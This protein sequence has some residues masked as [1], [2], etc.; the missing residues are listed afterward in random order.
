MD[1]LN[2]GDPLGYEPLR[3]EIALYLADARG[4]RCEPSQV[5]IVSGAQKAVG[6]AAMVLLDPGDTVWMEDPGYVTMRELICA[7]GARVAAVPVDQDGLDVEFGIDMAPNARMAVVTP[8]RQYPLGVLMSLPRRLALLEWA[9]TNRAWIIEDDYDSEFRFAGR[10]LASMQSLDTAGRVIYIGTF[11]KVLFPSLRIGYLVVPVDLIDA[12]RMACQVIDKAAS[13]IPQ[14]VLAE[15]M[16][17]GHFATHIRRMRSIYRERHEA[18]IDA[19]HRYLAGLLDVR[20]AD[21]GMN[22]IGWLA[23]GINDIEAQRRARVEGIV[24]NRMSY[25]YSDAPPRSGLHLGFC[26]T[27]PAQMSRHVQKLGTSLESLTAR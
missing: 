14:L 20:P 17:E 26:N 25:Y 3:R 23:N 12:T 22:V 11:S 21:S 13:T 18:F 24:T 19:S 8:S 7:Y 4:V 5:I 6:L 2:Y 15:F 16:A 27:S 9:Q 10:P 1:M